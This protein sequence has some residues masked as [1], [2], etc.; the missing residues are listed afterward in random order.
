MFVNLFFEKCI[1]IIV[2]SSSVISISEY[3]GNYLSYAVRENILCASGLFNLL[4]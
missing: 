1:Y 3:N 2:S 4:E